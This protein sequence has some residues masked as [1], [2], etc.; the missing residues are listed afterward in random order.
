MD[1]PS[2]DFITGVEEV[3]E[4]DA[5]GAYTFSS[6]FSEFYRVPFHVVFF[7]FLFQLLHMFV[8]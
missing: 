1:L 6:E 5:V 8:Y 4:R 3:S 2:H 7:Q